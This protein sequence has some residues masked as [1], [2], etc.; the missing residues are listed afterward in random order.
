MITMKPETRKPDCWPLKVQASDFASSRTTGFKGLG[1]R[2]LGC[3]QVEA[4]P[5]E[6]ETTLNL[7][8]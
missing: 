6:A 7:N 5:E 4:E 8:P 3:L 2:V 1:F